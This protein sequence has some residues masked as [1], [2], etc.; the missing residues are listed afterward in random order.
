MSTC[1]IR[2]KSTCDRSDDHFY[3]QICR[4]IPF[5]SIQFNS[6]EVNSMMVC[7]LLFTL[8]H[9]DCLLFC[10]R[11]AFFHHVF[12][13]CSPD[14]F[15]IRPN[16]VLCGGSCRKR[17][18]TFLATSFHFQWGIQM[19]WILDLRHSSNNNLHNIYFLSL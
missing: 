5:H 9:V 8:I 6:I 4:S 3:L 14:R 13:P 2:I 1:N 19:S 11:C 16:W 17:A 10:Q 7:V 18:L 12:V 15:S